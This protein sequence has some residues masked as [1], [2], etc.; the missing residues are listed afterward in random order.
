MTAALKMWPFVSV[1]N[2]TVVPPS[3]RLLVGSL[4]GVI[5]GVYLSLVSG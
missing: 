5:W 1:L 3:Q 4:F 2:F